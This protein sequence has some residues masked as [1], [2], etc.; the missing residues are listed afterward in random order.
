MEVLELTLSLVPVVSQVDPNAPSTSA[1]ATESQTGSQTGTDSGTQTGGQTG[2]D[3]GSQT[4]TGSS[5]QTSQAPTSSISINPVLPPGNIAMMTP[6]STVS[7]YIK[8]GN[9]ATFSWSYTSLIVTP[10]ALNIEAYCSMNGQTLTLATNHSITDTEFVWNTSEA[11]QSYDLL[12]AMYTLY[13][14]DST[15]NMSTIP[16]AGLLAPYQLPIG[17]YSGQPYTPFSGDATYENA[18]ALIEPLAV[19][20]IFAL[21]AVAIGSA[22]HVIFG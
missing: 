21:G 5:Q 11:T 22:L 9:Q 8:I 16:Q 10:T 17:I 1:S 13:M 4:A 19:K 3:S 12:T 18:G 7:T 15:G 6:A 2:T 14:F 20:F